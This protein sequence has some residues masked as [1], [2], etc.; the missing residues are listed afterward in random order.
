MAVVEVSVS[1]VLVQRPSSC[2]D[3]HPRQAFVRC[4]SRSS[5]SL[6]WFAALSLASGCCGGFMSLPRKPSLSLLGIQS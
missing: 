6:D 2:W 1:A 5:P 4:I 3:N